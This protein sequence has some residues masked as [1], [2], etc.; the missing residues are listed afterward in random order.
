MGRE[1]TR[2]HGSGTKKP[3]SIGIEGGSTRGSRASGR[4]ATASVCSAALPDDHA[5]VVVPGGD[6]A[7][8]AGDAEEDPDQGKAHLGARSREARPERSPGE[9]DGGEGQEGQAETNSDGGMDGS[10]HIRINLVCW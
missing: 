9:G 7:A 8:E 1:E 10:G 2:T 5:E 3:P 6:D 4:R